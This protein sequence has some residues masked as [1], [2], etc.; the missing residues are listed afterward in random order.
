MKPAYTSIH[1]VR[2]FKVN[3]LILHKSG[4]KKITTKL[5]NKLSNYVSI[6]NH[7]FRS[8]VTVSLFVL[9]SLITITCISR[10]MRVLNFSLF[11]TAAIAETADN[12]GPYGPCSNRTHKSLFFIKSTPGFI[13]YS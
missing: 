9:T 2:I 3:K 8:G 7:L 5:N 4:T 10:E 13:N 1:H 6:N 12:Y 11:Q